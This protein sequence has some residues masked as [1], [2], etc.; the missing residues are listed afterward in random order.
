MNYFDH[1]INSIK[2]IALTNDEREKA[3]RRLLEF[4][5][6]R[7]IRESASSP[8]EIYAGRVIPT[9][10]FNQF[11]L[12]PIPIML[13]AGL[14]L[15]GGVAFG[16]QDTLPGDALY[17]IKIAGE[18]IH[19]NL[20]VSSETGTRYEADLAG[21][22]LLEAEKLASQGKLKADAQATIE[23]NFKKHA[24]PWCCLRRNFEWPR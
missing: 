22:R 21:K 20:M 24:D 2:R 23:A 19:A 1:F 16:A 11:M 10:I 12:K 3:R 8:R 4:M 14:L 7:P 13:I 18:S 9:S 15:S 6:F 17:P 5:E